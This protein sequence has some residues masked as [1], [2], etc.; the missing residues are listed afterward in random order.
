MAYVQAP[1]TPDI[2]G[3]IVVPADESN[4][5]PGD[6]HPEVS[7]LHT[8]EEPADDVEVTPYYFS[9]QIWVSDGQGGW[10]QRRASTHAYADSDG[11]LFAM[12]PERYGAIANGVTSGMPYPADT[13]PGWSLNLQSRS[14]E[15]EGYAATI[16]VTMPRGG[17]QW[18]TTVRWVVAGNQMHGIPLDRAHTIGHYEVASNRTDPGTLD[19]DAVVEDAVRLLEKARESDMT[20]YKLMIDVNGATWLVACVE[21]F[22]YSRREINH[23]VGRDYLATIPDLNPPTKVGDVGEYTEGE[24][25]TI[26]IVGETSWS[27]HEHEVKG[28][29]R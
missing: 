11:D 26:P 24:F 29:A 1:F 6:N 3:S 22:P 8:P 18:N 23:K 2:P 7:V 12:V 25:D 15:A 14:L 10:V 17:P 5:R 27:T 16:G 21:R 20:N 9:R 28:T 4:V 13:Q 19:I